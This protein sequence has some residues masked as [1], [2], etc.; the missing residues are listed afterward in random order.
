MWTLGHSLLRYKYDIEYIKK[1]IRFFNK[2][3]F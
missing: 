1:V 3:N 2:K